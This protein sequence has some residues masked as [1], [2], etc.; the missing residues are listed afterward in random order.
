MREV[1]SRDLVNALLQSKEI[2]VDLEK[3]I[4]RVNASFCLTRSL[5]VEVD[6]S[7]KNLDTI[8]GSFYINVSIVLSEFILEVVGMEYYHYVNWWDLMMFHVEHPILLVRP[9]RIEK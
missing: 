7:R 2:K 8:T 9:T 1:R 3:K 4:Q 5:N 6:M